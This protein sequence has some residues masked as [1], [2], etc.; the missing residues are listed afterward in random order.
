M[1]LPG[2]IKVA[3]VPNP[4]MF[5]DTP[6]PASAVSAYDIAGGS[7]D[8]LPAAQAAAHVHRIILEKGGAPGQK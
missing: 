4:S 7:A 5:E 1:A 3:A 2:F 6:E 8:M